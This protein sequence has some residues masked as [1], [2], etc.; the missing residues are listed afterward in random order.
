MKLKDYLLSIIYIAIFCTLFTPLISSSL[1]FPFITG[2]AIFFR[3]L[4][5]IAF[6]SWTLLCLYDKKYLPKFSPINILATV[7]VCVVFIADIFSENPFKSFWSNFERM[8]GWFTI[9]YLWMYLIV[10]ESVIRVDKVWNYFLSTSVAVSIITVFYGL[11]QVLG[12]LDIHQSSDRIDATLGN[13]A[14]F[15]VY[16]LIHICIS[17]VLLWKYR[18]D[19]F[20]AAL[21]SIAIFGQL[22]ALYFTGT[23]GS[24]LGLLG[25]SIIA[26]LLFV[27]FSQN[28]K[29]KK[30]GIILLFCLISLTVVFISVK[31]SQF[32]R[33]N[34]V[35][36]RLAS[37]S[38][39]DAKPR[40]AIWSMAV[41]GFKE[42]PIIGW[43]QESFNY[44]FNKNYKPSMY[45]QEQWFDRAHNVF[46]DWLVAG[47]LLAFLSYLGLFCVSIIMLWRNNQGFDFVTKVII[48][49]GLTAYA[50]HNLFVFD[51][52]VS[53]ILFFVLLA[54]ISHSVRER[55][56]EINILKEVELNHDIRTLI[57]APLIL[58]VGVTFS[59]FTILKPAYAANTLSK[60]FSNYPEGPKKNL[61]YFKEVI[62]SNGVG[63]QEAAEQL[64]NFSDQIIK[65]NNS[66]SLK[67]EYYSL[68][69]KTFDNLLLQS[70]NDARLHYFIGTFLNSLGVIEPATQY[71]SKAVSLSPDKQTIIFVY[72]TSLINAGNFEEAF[73]LL[74]KAYDSAP[75]FDLAKQYY[76]VGAIHNGR[77]DI[78]DEILP[79]VEDKNFYKSELVISSYGATKNLK[80]LK[81][82]Y[83]KMINE[84]P[85]DYKTRIS[86]AAVKF[87]LN[88]RLGAIA[89]L[90]T[91]I[92]LNPNFKNQG[93][94]FINEIRA[95]RRP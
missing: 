90:E 13:A 28:S 75:E 4:V 36:N 38:L 16:L 79:L 34:K 6:I 27:F 87:D 64:I 91:A 61:E 37:I 1:Y 82:I 76:I 8:E 24:I 52:L 57:I 49:G 55:H 77:L 41:E 23:R 7:F 29:V 30:V 21:F 47:G 53:Y 84:D 54:Y 42:R 73:T 48:S 20:K 15:A 25:G 81:D 74:K 2:K 63:G 83:L 9:L 39:N 19:K 86:L 14:Y 46:L 51:H 68:T 88:D 31:D 89:E 10:L 60:V 22:L 43:G 17:A 58:I 44:V 33:Q 67:Q 35:L 45:A 80:R 95:G 40:L 32:V 70:P 94:H 62:E 69:R 3:A 71:L 66:D 11:L 85:S 78:V 72:A 65:S 18:Q 5:S 92:K 56:K 59:Y 26:G 50:I 93:Q 12:K